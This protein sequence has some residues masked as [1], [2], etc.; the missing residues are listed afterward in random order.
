MRG[1]GFPRAAGDPWHPG[2]PVGQRDA[3]KI[4][5]GKSAGTPGGDMAVFAAHG[6]HAPT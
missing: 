5:L 4:A 6:W 2:M 1:L 3:N